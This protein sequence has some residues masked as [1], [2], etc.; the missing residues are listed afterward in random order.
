MIKRHIDP[1]SH[2]ILDDCTTDVA[3]THLGLAERVVMDLQTGRRPH[4][5]NKNESPRKTETNLL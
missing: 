5:D 2:V 4:V 1:I 3:V